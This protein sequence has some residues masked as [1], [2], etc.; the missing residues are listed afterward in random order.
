MTNENLAALLKRDADL[1]DDKAAADLL[2]VSPGTLSVWR[3]T[4]RYNLPFL[5]VGRKVRY[6]RSA[7]LAWLE[8]RTRETGATA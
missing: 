4:G 3:S 5:K 1:L 8:S 2:D 7:L 6:R